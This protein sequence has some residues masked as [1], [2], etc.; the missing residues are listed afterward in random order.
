MPEMALNPNPCAAAAQNNHTKII[1]SAERT[2][3]GHELAE[4]T[5]TLGQQYLLLGPGQVWGL[6]QAT[7]AAKHKTDTALLYG[8]DLM[9]G[10]TAYGA[11]Q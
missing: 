6:I 7:H 1:T 4:R 8:G 11:L 5:D 10:S 2:C 9:T 3:I